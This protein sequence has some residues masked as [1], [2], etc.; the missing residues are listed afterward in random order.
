MAGGCIKSMLALCTVAGWLAKDSN[1]YVT[2]S[3]IG[4]SVFYYFPLII[5]WT[6]A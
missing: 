3:A 1:T 6:S 4:D 5:G 2:L